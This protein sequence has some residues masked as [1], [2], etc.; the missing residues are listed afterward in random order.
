MAT[1]QIRHNY[2]KE[3]EDGINSQII[4]ELNASYV[5]MAMATHFDRDDVA[6]KGVSNYFK[7][8]SNEEREHAQRLIDYQNLRGGQV[9]LTDLPKPTK[10]SWSSALEAFSDALDLEKVINQ[11]LLELHAIAGKHNDAHMTNFI[12][13]HYLDEQVTAIKELGDYVTLLKK[14]GPGLGEYLFDKHTLSG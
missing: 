12:E 8:S 5:Y 9:V 10:Q 4:K 1:S 3:S 13:E 6:L 7:K 14:A 2:S 11:A